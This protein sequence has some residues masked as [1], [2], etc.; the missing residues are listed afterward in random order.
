MIS[1]NNINK[2]HLPDFIPTRMLLLSVLISVTLLSCGIYKFNDAS[3]DPE[4]K[5]VKIGYIDNKAR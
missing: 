4:I 1:K 2:L 3:I 5:T